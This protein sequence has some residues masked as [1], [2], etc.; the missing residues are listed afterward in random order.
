M[1][2]T[3]SP[4]ARSL[5]RSS[6]LFR[7]ALLVSIACILSLNT[8]NLPIPLSSSFVKKISARTVHPSPRPVWR[9]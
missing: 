4:L 1:M 8:A 9:S 7:L 6:T 5:A 2:W 3:W